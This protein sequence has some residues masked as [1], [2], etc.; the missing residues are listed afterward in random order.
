MGTRPIQEYFLLFDLLFCCPLEDFPLK[1][2]SMLLQ[3]AF[4]SE[5]LDSE[6]NFSSEILTLQTGEGHFQPDSQNKILT[7]IFCGLVVLGVHFEKG[8]THV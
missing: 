5:L 3:S 8:L 2:G 1:E 6:L 7:F 4:S